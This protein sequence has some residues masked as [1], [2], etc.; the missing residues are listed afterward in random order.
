M[1]EIKFKVWSE[2]EKKMMIAKNAFDLYYYSEKYFEATHIMQYTGLKD[3][4]GK[5]IYEGDIV[6]I[7]PM[8]IFEKTVFKGEVKFCNGSWIVDNEKDCKYLFT[9]IDENKVIGN[10]Y[11][12]K[13]LL[14]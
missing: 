5:E 8:D 13:D 6:E 1:R 3:K 4:N 10:I 2:K 14:K 11:E 7:Y 12:D 9:E